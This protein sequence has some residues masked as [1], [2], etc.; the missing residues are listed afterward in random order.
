VSARPVRHP[1]HPFSFQ[2]IISHMRIGQT[3]LTA[4]GPFGPQGS[5]RHR[6]WRT[7]P[8]TRCVMGC[9][10]LITINHEYQEHGSIPQPDPTRKSRCQIAANERRQGIQFVKFDRR[11]LDVVHTAAPFREACRSSQ[12]SD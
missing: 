8:S 9:T 6:G 4:T 7:G 3:S 2:F 12:I 11:G 1:V 5:P 10:T